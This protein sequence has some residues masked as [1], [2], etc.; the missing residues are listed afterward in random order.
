[1]AP[2]E[3]R[4]AVVPREACATIGPTRGLRRLGTEL[5]LV[6]RRVSRVATELGLVSAVGLAGL[7]PLGLVGCSRA[8]PHKDAEDS[9]APIHPGP[10]RIELRVAAASDL[11]DAFAEIAAAHEAEA[12][13][14]LAFTFGSSGLL[15][16]QVA[17]GAPFDAFAS[18]NVDFAD[19]AARSGACDASTR[20]AYARGRL[21][22]HCPKG[23]PSGGLAGLED[24][25][26]RVVAIAT[27]EH[28]PYGKAAINALE[29]AGVASRL[30]SKIVFA[31]NV[32]ESLQFARSGNADC[33]FVSKALVRTLPASQVL[34]LPLDS[35]APIVQALVLCGPNAP[36]GLAASRKD[37]ASAFSA[38]VR[39]DR[40]QAILAKYGF[41][42]PAGT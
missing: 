26:F 39:S 30:E 3:E 36:T 4:R 10:G 2:P 42:R 25:R 6:S 23:V 29:R 38:F 35:Y 22:L 16:K 18:A 33:A 37:A 40:G 24:P 15:A 41:E 7:G 13:V 1:M 20:V 14:K 19:A 21:V 27:P 31:G 34:D 32:G 12:H 17:E 8:S 28:A 5:A 9:E 11:T